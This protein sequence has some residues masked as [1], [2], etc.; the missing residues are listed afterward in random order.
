M[1]YEV[2]TKLITDGDFGQKTYDAVLNYQKKNFINPFDHDG[3]VGSKTWSLMQ[4]QLSDLPIETKSLPKNIIEIN[5]LDL[6]LSIQ[7]KRADTIDLNNFI[8]SGYQW[9]H[10]NGVTYPLSMMVSEGKIIHNGQPHGKSAG[11]LIVYKDGSVNCKPILDIT[12][13]KNVCFAVGGCSIYPQIKMKEEGF[14][15]IYSDIGR[16]TDRPMIA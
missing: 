2:I 12:K 3:I 8:T 1:L 14:T 13:E 7:D 11:T 15:G 5:P 16:N 10:K 6:K 4:K 9:H